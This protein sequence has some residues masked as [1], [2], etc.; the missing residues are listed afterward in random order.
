MASGREALR[1]RCEERA[2]DKK[3]ASGAR[4]VV[5]SGKMVSSAF[6]IWKGGDGGEGRFVVKFNFKLQSQHWPEGRVRM[7]ALPPFA[8]D[9]QKDD[10]LMS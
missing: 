10:T 1:K 8:L 7:E 5:Q 4:E 3:S 9:L 2:Y 6:V